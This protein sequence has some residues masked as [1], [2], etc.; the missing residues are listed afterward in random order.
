LYVSD[1]KYLL[2]RNAIAD[3]DSCEAD[4]PGS[5]DGSRQNARVIRKPPSAAIEELGA[6][7][8]MQI[9]RLKVSGRWKSYLAEFA[10]RAA[11]ETGCPHPRG[12]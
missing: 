2:S 6:L 4:R 8:L 10:E 12:D 1:N 5:S 7:S 9:V 3:L 11:R